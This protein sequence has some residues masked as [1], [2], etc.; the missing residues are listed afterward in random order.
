[1]NR[2]RPHLPWYLVLYSASSSQM[3]YT[4]SWYPRVPHMHP[5]SPNLY[6]CYIKSSESS[7]AHGISASPSCCSSCRTYETC[8]NCACYKAGHL[9]IRAVSKKW[10][11][12]CLS[13]VI[14][15]DAATAAAAAPA[16]VE[17]MEVAPVAVVVE[18]ETIKFK[19]TP[20]LKFL[21]DLSFA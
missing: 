7:V 11:C 14:K 6:Y 16:P 13:H 4:L 3:L 20:I 18:I 12:A 2:V 1:M 15:M 17:G 8:Q 19:V 5:N 21:I 9:C 10:Y